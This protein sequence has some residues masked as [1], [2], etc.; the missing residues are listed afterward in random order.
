MRLLLILLAVTC[1]L[2]L[3]YAIQYYAGGPVR[4][5]VAVEVKA[6]AFQPGSSQLATAANDGTVRLWQTDQ[7]WAMR[8]LRGHSRLVV[9]MA[10]SPDGTTLVSAGRDGTVRVWDTATAQAKATLNDNSG[11]LNGASL[12]ADGSLYATIGDDG[13]VRIWDLA[14]GQVIN[15]IEPGANTKY[16]VA[17]SA[18]GS[19]VAAG[20]GSNVQ[21]WNAR[22]GEVVRRLEGYWEDP[23]T[24]KDWLGHKKQVTSLAFSPDGQ[25][26]ASGAADATCLFWTLETGE[27]K[28]T[29]EG[30]WGAVTSLAFSQDGKTVL[31]G[32]GDNKIRAWRIP[33]GTFIAVYQGHLSSVNGLAFGPTPDS[34]FSVGD[35]GTIREWETANQKVTRIEWIQIGYQPQWGKLLAA[36]ALAS[37]LVGLVCLWG[38]RKLKTWSHLFALALFLIGPIVVLGLPFFEVFPYPLVGALAKILIFLIN[39]L[40]VLA[41]LAAIV[42]LLI[43]GYKATRGEPPSLVLAIGLGLALVVLAVL[44]YWKVI[45]LGHSFG[46]GKLITPPSGP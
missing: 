20:D 46:L 44:Y 19:L 1:A 37:G 34:L 41:A 45:P 39:I 29:A 30:H 43:L 38:L 12:A 3:L 8:I 18:D 2:S 9:G 23:E 22:S 24:K 14:I 28:W 35:D 13:I 6:L 27:V 5:P 15:R 40:L 36:W 33:G 42:R 11:P 4:L 25:F 32:S 10:F 26:L 21:V 31:S 17:L 7:D 16:V